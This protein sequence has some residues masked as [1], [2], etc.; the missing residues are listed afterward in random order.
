M[1]REANLLVTLAISE[2]LQNTR[3][4]GRRKYSRMSVLEIAEWGI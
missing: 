4:K 2:S 1:Y 3:L